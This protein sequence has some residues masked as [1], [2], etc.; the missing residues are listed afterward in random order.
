MLIYKTPFSDEGGGGGLRGGR[1]LVVEETFS[2]VG[3]LLLQLLQLLQARQLS[4]KRK[5]LINL[6]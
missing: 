5:R 2:N 6:E 3:T 4:T 1:V